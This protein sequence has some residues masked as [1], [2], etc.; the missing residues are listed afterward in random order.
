[1]EQERPLGTSPP[2]GGH[3]DTFE[4]EGAASSR[5]LC[6]VLPHLFVVLE[7]DNPMAGGARHALLGID[8]V[9]IGRGTQRT[10][11]REMSAGVTRLFLKIPGKSLSSTH[12]RIV[13]DGDQWILEDASS[14]NGTFLNGTLV[15]RA[16]VGDG[17]LIDVGHTILTLRY[18]LPTPPETGLDWDMTGGPTHSAITLLPLL[19]REFEELTSLASSNVPI[20]LVGGTG[21]GKEMHARMMHRLS[22]R[23]GKFVAVNCGALPPNLVESQLFGHVRGAFSGAVRDEPGFL[24]EANGGT[25]LLDEVGDLPA[26]AQAALLRVLQ[27]N[28]IVPVGTARPVAVELRVITAAHQPLEALVQAGRFRPDLRARLEGFVRELPDLCD[29][30]EDLGVLVA[31]LLE[32]VVVGAKVSFKPDAGRALC[33][34]DWPMNIRELEQ[35]LKRAVALAPNGVIE[36]RHLPAAV[37]EAP[38]HWRPPSTPNFWQDE[39]LLRQELVTKL[40]EHAGNVAQVARAMGR[41]R[42]QVHRWMTR[43]SLDPQDFRKKST[44]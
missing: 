9:V 6:P 31:A 43:L 8:E 34:Y 36:R 37:A 13:R 26:A 15:E 40:Q 38:T 20:V 5:R 32:K 3:E 39:A 27:E 14:K 24:R 10:A 19:A 7:C 41:A 25:L 28:E 17:D 16:R 35:C 44:S 4:D 23:A 42:M 29:R 21:T 12:A 1:M 22:K 33:C 18:G 30:R 11:T 2:A